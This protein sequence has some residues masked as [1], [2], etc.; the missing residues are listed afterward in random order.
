MPLTV[1]VHIYGLLGCNTVAHGDLEVPEFSC[2][3]L[4]GRKMEVTCYCEMS[5]SLRSAWHYGSED[6]FSIFSNV[7]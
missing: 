6:C 1:R 3:L 5:G 7:S 4:F 2:G